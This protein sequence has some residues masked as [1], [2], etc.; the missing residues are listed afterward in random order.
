M[1][2]ISQLRRTIAQHPLPDLDAA[3]ARRCALAAAVRNVSRGGWGTDID[4]DRLPEEQ[5]PWRQQRAL[6]FFPITWALSLRVALLWLAV[7]DLTVFM[8]ARIH[9]RPIDTVLATLADRLA[10]IL[11]FSPLGA[12]L[13]AAGSASPAAQHI[14]AYWALD[15]VAFCIVGTVLICVAPAEFAAFARVIAAILVESNGWADFLYRTF[16]GGLIV[17]GLGWTLFA[18]NMFGAYPATF[19][20]EF[21][22]KT[23]GIIE[24]GALHAGLAFIFPLIFLMWC[25]AVIGSIDAIARFFRRSSGP[26][27]E[28]R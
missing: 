11:S 17:A 5:V 1:S 21:G 3:A 12:R 7:I 22:R 13:A 14:F 19:G 18:W 27:Q 28:N 15:T 6:P 20:D 24:I 25:S 2:L 23:L 4:L 9:L 8:L 10:P 26:T 16:V